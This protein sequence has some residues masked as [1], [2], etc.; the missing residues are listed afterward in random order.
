MD[1]RNFIWQAKQNQ[2][3]LQLQVTPLLLVVSANH[4]YLESDVITVWIVATKL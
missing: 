2:T 3:A 1:M 4:I